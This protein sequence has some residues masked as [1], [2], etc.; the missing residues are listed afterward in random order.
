[1]ELSPS[2]KLIGFNINIVPWHKDFSFTAVVNSH[3]CY[4]TYIADLAK[5]QEIPTRRSSVSEELILVTRR[6]NLSISCRSTTVVGEI[7]M[8]KFLRMTFSAKGVGILSRMST[9]ILSITSSRVSPPSSSPIHMVEKRHRA[10][11]I[12]R[13]PLINIIHMMLDDII[14]TCLR[15]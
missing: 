3:T 9:A 12:Y 7:L 2:H 13:Y 10:I 15:L 5:R 8:P 6:L 14:L 4:H 11:Y 1:M